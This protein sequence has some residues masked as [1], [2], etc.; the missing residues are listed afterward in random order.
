MKALISGQAGV[1]VLIE[2]D[3]LSSLH[4]DETEAT[5]LNEEDLPYLLADTTDLSQL[6]D[7]TIDAVSVALEL[8]YQK[9]QSLHLILILLDREADPEVRRLAAE[10][11]EESFTNPEVFNFIRNRLCEPQP[12]PPQNMDLPGARVHAQGVRTLRLVEF[13]NDLGSYLAL[14]DYADISIDR[15]QQATH[16]SWGR[17]QTN[18]TQR[19]A[20]DKE[21]KRETEGSPSSTERRIV[22]YGRKASPLG[23]SRIKKAVKAVARTKKAEQSSE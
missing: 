23:R 1:A 9:D 7:T 14:K 18:S 20:F 3:H 13:L 2:E 21:E 12:S 5:P 11:L 8:A 4:V 16:E 19:T 22:K 17:G 10:C 6:E 15:E